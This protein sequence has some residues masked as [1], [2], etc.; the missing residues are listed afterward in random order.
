MYGLKRF[1]AEGVVGYFMFHGCPESFG[2]QPRFR[3][4]VLKLYFDLLHGFFQGGDC[5]DFSATGIK[6]L[7]SKGGQVQRKQNMSRPGFNPS[8][9]YFIGPGIE[10][11]GGMAIVRFFLQE[12]AVR[13]PNDLR[14][15]MQ[16][17][18]CLIVV[19]HITFLNKQSKKEN[20]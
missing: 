5:Q 17:P 7:K 4:P 11:Q 1:F 9:H 10:I 12:G 19:L 15:Q 14:K 16:L 20:C 6:H 2:I 3:E 8:T 13:L 18:V